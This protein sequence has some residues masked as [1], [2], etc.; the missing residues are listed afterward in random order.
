MIARRY[1][2]ESAGCGDL[3]VNCTMLL[4]VFDPALSRGSPRTGSSGNRSARLPM[5][6]LD[7]ERLLV[8]GFRRGSF[9]DSL[10]SQIK[11]LRRD[12]SSTNCTRASA[13]GELRAVLDH[14]K[15]RVDWY[16]GTLH[17]I[18]QAPGL[19]PVATPVA[20]TASA[21]IRREEIRGGQRRPWATSVAPSSAAGMTGAEQRIE[22][23]HGQTPEVS[24]GEGIHRSGNEPAT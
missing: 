18:E 24:S 8:V 22:H 10:R 20:A 23:G 17:V 1:F 15:L 4:I 13:P 9:E 21:S 16:T 11:H 14:Q 3:N 2:G 5:M 19:S 7:L 6:A 12:V